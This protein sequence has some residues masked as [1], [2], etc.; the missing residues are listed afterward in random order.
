MSVVGETG[1]ASWAARSAEAPPK[2]SSVGEVVVLLVDMILVEFVFLVA[3]WAGAGSGGWIG[4]VVRLGVGGGVEGA[5][6]R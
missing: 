5:R 1:A 6:V 3:V 2:V 4:S